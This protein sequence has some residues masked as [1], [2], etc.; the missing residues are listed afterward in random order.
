MILIHYEYDDKCSSDCEK[1]FA[2]HSYPST[3]RGMYEPNDQT[4]NDGNNRQ[5]YRDKK[6]WFAVCS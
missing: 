4:F 6:T 3:C 5:R 2:T 1:D